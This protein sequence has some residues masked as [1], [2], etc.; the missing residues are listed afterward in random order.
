MLVGLVG[1]AGF[2]IGSLVIGWRRRT[3]QARSGTLAVGAL[4]AVAWVAAFS[5]W[6]SSLSP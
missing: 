1:T 3:W 6:V 2:G 5:W 4:L